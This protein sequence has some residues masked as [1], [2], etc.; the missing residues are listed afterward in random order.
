MNPHRVYRSKTTPWLIAV[1]VLALVVLVDAL[2]RLWGDGGTTERA[3]AGPLIVLG[4]V[5]VLSGF[6]VRYWIADSVLHI[7]ASLFRWRI[8][9][10]SIISVKPSRSWMSAPALSLDRLEILHKRGTVWI[11][12]RDEEQFLRELEQAQGDAKP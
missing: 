8:P 10:D 5:L 3:I 2:W 1:M 7:R 11:S 6:R 4:I 12:P 9:V